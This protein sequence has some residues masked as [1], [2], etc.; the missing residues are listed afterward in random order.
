MQK[1]HQCRVT[2]TRYY[3]GRKLYPVVTWDSEAL[4][5]MCTWLGTV[6]N[7]LVDW[8]IVDLHPTWNSGKSIGWLVDWLIVDLCLTW[9]SSKSIVWL[10]D[11]LMV[12][13]CLT[14]DSS[15]SIG[16]LVDCRFA[17]NVYFVIEKKES[18]YLIIDQNGRCPVY[19][20]VNQVINRSTC[21]CPKLSTVIL[22]RPMSQV[23]TG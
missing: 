17:F 13:L 2:D 18:K 11:W 5:I 6:A 10:V 22:D 3:G 15:K 19:R 12:D 23:T 16:W 9:D 21:D 20:S 14:W 7:P 1:T 8:L 4:H